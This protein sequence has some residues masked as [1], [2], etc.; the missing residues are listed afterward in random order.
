[1][2]APWGYA[3]RQELCQQLISFQTV[4]M[5]SNGTSDLAG[6]LISLNDIACIDKCIVTS[7]HS[8][9]LWDW[10]GEYDFAARKPGGSQFLIDNNPLQISQYIAPGPIRQHRSKNLISFA[11]SKKFTL[12][13]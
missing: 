8:N 11:L 2:K 12:L 7:F 13:F 4:H 3:R 5:R 10:C 1:M 9:K 6:D